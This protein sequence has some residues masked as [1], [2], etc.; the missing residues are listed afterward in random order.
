[1]LAQIN[2]LS[3]WASTQAVVATKDIGT[4][5][6]MVRDRLVNEGAY[7]DGDLAAGQAPSDAGHSAYRLTNFITKLPVRGNAEQYASAFGLML[8]SMDNIRSRV[9]M[10]FEPNDTDADNS[11]SGV[12]E[13]TGRQVEAWV[14]VPVVGVGW[15]AVVPTPERTETTLKS[16]SPSPP[17]PEYETQAP[18]PPPLVDPDFDAPAASRTKAEDT[19]EPDDPTLTPTKNVTAPAASSGGGA[20]RIVAVAAGSPL[21]VLALV[22]GIIVFLKARRRRRRQTRGTPNE[23]VANGWLELTD[24]ALGHA[25]ATDV[26]SA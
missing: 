1:M 9:V 21:L 8:R 15:V 7:S 4:R 22:I 20:G 18:P 3:T 16:K 19:R 26:H 10:G 24:H 2:E 6:D 14:E 13:V 11:E 17:E 23:R 25:D 12:V 5:I